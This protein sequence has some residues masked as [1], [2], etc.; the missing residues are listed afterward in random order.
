MPEEAYYWNYAM[1]P[2]FGYLDHPPMVAWLIRLGTAIFGNTE[3]GVRIMA[4][5]GSL[6]S[7]FFIY[8]LTRLLYNRAAACHSILLLQLAPIFFFTGFIMTPDSPLIVFWSASLYF[9]AR[10]FFLGD[11]RS[12]IWFGMSLGL[13][14]LSKYTAALLMLALAVFLILDPPS[15]VWL[16]R[17]APYL[18][19]AVAMLIFLPV[20][21]WNWQHQWIS[22]AFQTTG[23]LSEQPRFSLHMLIGSILVVLTPLG[24]GI[25]TLL[26][27]FRRRPETA[28]ETASTERR[29]IL[30]ERVFTLVPLSVFVMFSLVHRVKLNWTGPIWLA[31]IPAMAACLLTLPKE[32]LFRRRWLPLTILMVAVFYLGLLQYLSTGIPGMGYLGVIKTVPV[33]W[34]EFGR[35]LDRRK[36]ALEKATGGAVRIVGMDKYFIASEAAFYQKNQAVAVRETTGAHL[37]GGNSLMYQLW[38][39]AAEQRG[40]TLLLVA[41]DRMDLDRPDIP[42]LSTSCGP[43]EE[44]WLERG[45]KKTY[46]LTTCRSFRITLDDSLQK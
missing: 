3:F 6:V 39:P 14:L 13:G 27:A 22:F 2:A 25:A 19:T 36:G 10:I 4:L 33:G 20:I 7:A 32:S 11:S 12:W 45:G 31:L 42:K 8:Q 46:A 26:L 29:R 21:F 30:F 34:S 15:R 37:F 16:R 43:V 38:S 24:A 17:F 28:G 9:L 5:L 35:E 23:R 1:H 41:F 44:L 18:A 40:A